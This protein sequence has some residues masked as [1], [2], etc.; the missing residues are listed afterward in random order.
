MA[1]DQPQTPHPAGQPSPVSS[2][3]RQDPGELR[4]AQ[5]GTQH[6]AGHQAAAA[7]AGQATVTILAAVQL[8]WQIFSLPKHSKSL[9]NWVSCNW[10]LHTH[11]ARCRETI[12]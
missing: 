9:S 8:T 4:G 10:L 3:D 5:P 1:V 2:Q 6:Q 12:L 11:A 7:A